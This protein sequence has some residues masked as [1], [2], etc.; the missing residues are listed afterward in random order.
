MHS[1]NVF[2]AS[3]T[4][5]PN[6]SDMPDDDLMLAFARG[7]ARAF[8]ALYARHESALLRF[9]RRLMGAQLAAQV[10]EVFQETWLRIIAARDSFVAQGADDQKTGARWRTWAFTIAHNAAMDRLRVSGREVSVDGQDEGEDMLDWLQAKLD[11][12]HPADEDE[13]YWRAA[14]RQ[15]LHCLDELPADQRA[16]FLL[17]YE[18]EDTVEGLATR[19]GLAFE[20]AKSRLRYAL[21]K[22]RHCMRRYLVE[23]E[24]GT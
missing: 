6:T 20:T 5:A 8:E 18:D 22:L 16:A 2:M 13:A 4:N 7:D 3:T 17:H 24:A 15:M 1:D 23:M 21:K 19:L 11:R 12:S 9:L 10:E 14:G